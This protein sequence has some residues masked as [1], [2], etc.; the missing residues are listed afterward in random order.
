LRLLASLVLIC[1]ALPL[2]LSAAPKTG[3]IS[4]MSIDTAIQAAFYNFMAAGPE[5]GAPLTQAGAIAYGKDVVARLKAMAKGDPNEKYIL[6]KVSELEGQ[7]YLEEKEVLLKRMYQSTTATNDLIA[8]F[9]AETGKQRPDFSVL[10]ALCEQVGDLNAEKGDNL[11]RLIEKRRAALAREVPFL[12]RAAV[13]KADWPTARREL[14]YLK[15]SRK[16]LPIDNQCIPSLDNRLM[17]E[18]GTTN[19]R[20]AVGASLSRL[21]SALRF[22][23]VGTTRSELNLLDQLLSR[24]RLPAAESQSYTRQVSAARVGLAAIE[25]SLLARADVLLADKGT[26]AAIDYVNRTLRPLGVSRER[27]A[28]IENR[29]AATGPLSIDQADTAVSRELAKL[30][31][32]EP[33][34]GALSLGDVQARARAKAQARADSTRIAQEDEYR[35]THAGEIAARDKAEKERA[36]QQVAAAKVR[37]EIEHLLAADKP[38]KARSL[39]TKKRPV[40]SALDDFD[41][42]TARLEA[43]ESAQRESD[44]P[45]AS[46]TAYLPAADP[47]ATVVEIYT[48]LDAGDV[49]AAAARFERDRSLLGRV[50]GIRACPADS[51]L[52]RCPGSGRC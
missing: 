30:S 7:I 47:T 10:T 13:D 24:N 4:Q 5:A 2:S 52:A 22:S 41:A 1:C 25:D 20:D 29:I 16:Y 49:A 31:T 26:D 28:G 36:R 51:P 6:W 32:D 45:A 27:I 9:N 11:W 33:A 18:E 17:L 44:A 38:G 23:D 50:G 21:Q 42:L 35:R 39:Y 46:P 40:L 37:D 15:K 34:G 12:A 43:A 14:D 8:K 48:L 19:Y 3:Y